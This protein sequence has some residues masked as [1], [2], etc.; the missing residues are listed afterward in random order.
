MPSIPHT[1]LRVDDVIQRGDFRYTVL[2]VSRGTTGQGD[3]IT[4]VICSH[5]YGRDGLRLWYAR[6]EREQIEERP[7]RS[8]GEIHRAQQ[9]ADAPYELLTRLRR[10][11]LEHQNARIHLTQGDWR[12]ALKA[13]I[14][15]I[16]AVL[17]V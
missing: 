11:M 15:A 13:W 9:A 6:N 17:S 16:D 5:G 8:I 2:T 12:R 1:E 14:A 3:P 4:E 7:I 10:E